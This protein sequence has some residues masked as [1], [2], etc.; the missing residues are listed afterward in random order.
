MPIVIT[1]P[2]LRTIVRE[3][4][5]DIFSGTNQSRQI[6]EHLPRYTR[7]V[8]ISIWKI[9]PFDVGTLQIGHGAVAGTRDTI[10]TAAEVDVTSAGLSKAEAWRGGLNDL[11]DEDRVAINFRLEDAV[12]TKGRIQVWFTVFE[13]TVL[14]GQ[15]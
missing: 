11:L 9:V 13:E 3:I 7:V 12:P 2:R 14:P 8:D 15:L 1:E 6:G 4:E 10:A 5:H